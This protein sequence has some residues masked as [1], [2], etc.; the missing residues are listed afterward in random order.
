LADQPFLQLKF[1]TASLPI[2]CSDALLPLSSS[3]IAAPSIRKKSS[4]GHGLRPQDE[5][6]RLRRHSPTLLPSSTIPREIAMFAYIQVSSI[7]TDYETQLLLVWDVA[8]AVAQRHEFH[9]NA[10]P[11]CSRRLHA[12]MVL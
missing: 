10:P 8:G 1:L 3:R 5:E 4:S 12:I 6:G 9:N 7:S 11:A 2:P